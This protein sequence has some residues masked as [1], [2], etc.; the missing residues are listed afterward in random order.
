MI[1]LFKTDNYGAV[2]V[3]DCMLDLE[4]S[5]LEEGI[6]IISIDEVFDTIE[7]YGFYAENIT[8]ETINEFLKLNLP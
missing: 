8:E 6:E 2:K 4:G 5:N 3:R 1:K 7:L